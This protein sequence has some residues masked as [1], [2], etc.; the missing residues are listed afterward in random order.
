MMYKLE[1]DHHF[2]SRCVQLSSHLIPMPYIAYIYSNKTFTL[3]KHTLTLIMH[4]LSKF[5]KAYLI[6]MHRKVRTELLKLIHNNN[7]LNLLF[8]VKSYISN[9]WTLVNSN[10]DNLPS[11]D[12]LTS[13]QVI[14]NGDWVNI[15]CA[16]SFPEQ[17]PM[18]NHGHMIA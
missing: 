16:Y 3:I 15:R 6:D 18:F 8:R 12:S 7:D 11:I 10:A 1:I 13:A 9:G 17:L 4:I 14:Y 2:E 5:Y